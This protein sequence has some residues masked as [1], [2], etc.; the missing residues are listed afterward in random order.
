MNHVMVGGMVSYLSKPTRT[1]L[2][3]YPFAPLRTKL[4]AIRRMAAG[5]LWYLKNIS[6][7]ACRS[8]VTRWRTVVP[9]LTGRRG[10]WG[11]CI[12]RM[13]GPPARLAYK[14]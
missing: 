8:L 6:N 7:V 12:Y 13:P 9:T 1:P 3:H 14:A 11:F 5:R 4:Y 2:V 10:E